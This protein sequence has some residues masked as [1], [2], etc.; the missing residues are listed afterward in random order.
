[1]EGSGYVDEIQYLRLVDK[2]VQDWRSRHNGEGPDRQTLGNIKRGS[3]WEIDQAPTATD[4]PVDVPTGNARVQQHEEFVNR[5]LDLW[6]LEFE[7][8]N[9]RKPTQKEANDA[10]GRYEATAFLAES[11]N[12]SIPPV[13]G[14]PDPPLPGDSRDVAI[15]KYKRLYWMVH[16]TP[17]GIDDV[18]T[19]ASHWDQGIETDVPDL[20][21][22]AEANLAQPLGPPPY[23]KPYEKAKLLNRRLEDWRDLHE[24]KAPNEETLT[25][26]EVQVV[27]DVDAAGHDR[28]LPEL[29]SEQMA[30]RRD[31]YVNWQ[32]ETWETEFE[33]RNGRRPDATEW[34]L[35]RGDIEW[36]ATD[37]WRRSNYPQRD[38]PVEPAVTPL[39]VQ[40]PVEAVT[41][42]QPALPIRAIGAGAVILILIIVIILIS[43]GVLGG[44]VALRAVSTPSPSAS[45]TPSASPSATAL[46]VAPSPSSP[47]ADGPVPYLRRPSSTGGGAGSP[48]VA[49]VSLQFLVVDPGNTHAGES[50]VVVVTGQGAGTYTVK[51]NPD[52][53][54]AVPLPGVP[55]PD[56]TTSVGTIQSI[57]SRSAVVQGTVTPK[58]PPIGDLCT[59]IG[60]ARA[61]AILGGPA[62][63]LPAPLYCAISPAGGSVTIRGVKY[64]TVTLALTPAG[65]VQGGAAAYAAALAKEQA[66]GTAVA[67]SGL[68]DKA[69]FGSNGLNVVKGDVYL[70]VAS[71]AI[72]DPK[73]VGADA[74]VFVLK[75]FA[76]IV[77]AAV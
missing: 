38:R 52:G 59:I 10:R 18:G 73:Q 3:R 34:S 57:G 68:G 27:Q 74:P 77:L 42:A 14:L 24:G 31:D 6:N 56:V 9:G 75:Q 69:F 39:P 32:M 1:M 76:E 49:I 2:R 58:P 65:G 13:D 64:I 46:A 30:A 22:Q 23:D 29:T 28:P 60:P 21:A 4:G 63:F 20:V 45:A 40:P 51:V 33:A 48:C 8:D 67:V 11:A 71:T 35:A 36:A 16:H 55:C 44:S 61:A 19:F 72:F 54:I 43:T 62:T 12:A 70:L 17:P 47:A 15:D 66:A 50:V 53:T 41:T 26:I 25:Q 5:S 7:T 37:N